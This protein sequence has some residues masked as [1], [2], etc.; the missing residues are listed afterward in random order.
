LDA[1][2]ELVAGLAL[3]GL[4]SVSKSRSGNLGETPDHRAWD[5]SAIKAREHYNTANDYLF[6]AP[7]VKLIGW[8]GVPNNEFRLGRTVRMRGSRRYFPLFRYADSE[9]GNPQWYVVQ[10]SPEDQFVYL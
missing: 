3:V 8:E 6:T 10:W 7:V 1:V 4:A 9:G 5:E 2:K